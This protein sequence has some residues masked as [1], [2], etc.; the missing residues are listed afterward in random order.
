M[1][2][3]NAAGIKHHQKALGKMRL[4]GGDSVL[5]AVEPDFDLLGAASTYATHLEHITEVSRASYRARDLVS[6]ERLTGREV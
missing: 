6:L 2:A 5:L 1:A 4:L 3:S